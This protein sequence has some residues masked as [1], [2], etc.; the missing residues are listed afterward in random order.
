M[1]AWN[2]G[3]RGRTF[4]Q[5]PYNPFNVSNRCI[6]SKGESG[7]GDGAPQNMMKSCAG[8]HLQQILK[9]SPAFRVLLDRKH[10]NLWKCSVLGHLDWVKIFPKFLCFRLGYVAGHRK[11]E[12]SE[13]MSEVF[14]NAAI[15]CDVLVICVLL[16]WNC[17]EH[18]HSA[19]R[20]GS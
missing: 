6:C 20:G 9:I 8:A 16:C 5:L 13:K 4:L 7:L 2:V 10:G 1:E 11:G 18:N 14:D 3:K 12:I 15:S 19:S 17:T